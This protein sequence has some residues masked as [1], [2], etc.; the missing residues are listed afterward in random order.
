M[1]KKVAISVGDLNGIGIEIALRT[2]KQITKMV[3]PIYII[4]KKML[5]QAAHLLGMDIPK[6]FKTIAPEAKSFTIKPG[7]VS[8]KS[9]AYSFASFKKL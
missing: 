4:D 2:H 3:E 1:K 5:R 8:K 7:K 6:D 9:G